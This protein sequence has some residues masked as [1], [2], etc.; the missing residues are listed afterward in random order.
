[1]TD[2]SIREEAIASLRSRGIAIEPHLVAHEM[3]IVWTR[4]VVEARHA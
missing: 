2:R 1:M 4:R 3:K